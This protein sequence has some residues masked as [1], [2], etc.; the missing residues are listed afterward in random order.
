MTKIE[1]LNSS[2]GAVLG[3]GLF[4]IVDNGI[5]LYSEACSHRFN[6]RAIVCNL[7][8]FALSWRQ[9]RGIYWRERIHS[10]VL[11]SQSMVISSRKR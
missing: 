3:A 10:S 8:S 11:S 5:Y 4:E 9:I 1:S 7:N 6:V 2:P